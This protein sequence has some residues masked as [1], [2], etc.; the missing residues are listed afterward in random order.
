MATVFPSQGAEMS[1]QHERYPIYT[2][3]NDFPIFA[4]SS[5]E[6][7]A[8]AQE[9]D[10][11][12]VVLKGSRA[13]KVEKQSLSETYVDMRAAYLKDGRLVAHADGKSLEFITDVSFKSPTAAASVISGTSV[14]GRDFWFEGWASGCPCRREKPRIYY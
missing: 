10:G 2:S 11:Q 6:Y 9:V 12:F 7:S 4:A 8:E 3:V 5:Q 13:R 14:N 1:F